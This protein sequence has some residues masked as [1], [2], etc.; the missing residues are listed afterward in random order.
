M[1]L[2]K[3]SK[4]SKSES[5]VLI[6]W[7]TVVKVRFLGV[8]V[9][10]C[11]DWNIPMHRLGSFVWLPWVYMS[12]HVV[13]PLEVYTCLMPDGRCNCHPLQSTAKWA[14]PVEGPTVEKTPLQ[15]PTGS[16]RSTESHAVVSQEHSSWERHNYHPARLA[17]SSYFTGKWRSIYKLFQLLPL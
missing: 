7:N 8:S 16:L 5:F 9:Y 17:G 6:V 4:M 13:P 12:I 2:E 3:K 15:I 1:V 10:S 14:R 11:V